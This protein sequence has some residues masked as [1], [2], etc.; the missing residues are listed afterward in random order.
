[1]NAHLASSSD[2]DGDPF[3]ARPAFATLPA[4]RVDIAD[5]QAYVSIDER[6][7]REVVGTVLSRE[8]VES[9][10]VSVGLVDDEAIHAINRR[11]L[12]HDHPTDVLSFRLD[13]T[14]PLDE[15]S[16]RSDV[17]RLQGEIVIS[18][19]TALRVASEIGAAFEDELTLYLVHGL[20]HLCGYDDHHTEDRLRMRQRETTLLN[21]WNIRPHDVD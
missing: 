16:P 21:L 18:A 11:F 19:E 3:D 15:S 12:S 4:Q 8:G 6:R 7:V 20:L 14:L 9:F 5:E 17:T 10:E 2:T 1:M 13:E